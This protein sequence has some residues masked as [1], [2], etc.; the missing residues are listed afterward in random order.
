MPGVVQGADSLHSKA[1]LRRLQ[2]LNG[3][4]NLDLED[5][6]NTQDY[7]EYQSPDSRVIGGATDIYI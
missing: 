6:Q 3:T 5:R 4:G 2:I 1:G 7:R